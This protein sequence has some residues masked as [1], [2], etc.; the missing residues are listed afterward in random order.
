[1]EEETASRTQALTEQVRLLKAQLPLLLSRLSQIPDVRNPKKLKHKLTHLLLY[2]LLMFVYQYGSRREVNREM[3]RAMFQQ[4]LRELFPELAQLPHADT[5]YRLLEKIDVEAIQEAHIEFIRKLMKGKKFR[6]YLINN[7]YPVAID[8]TQ[9]LATELLWGEELLQ[10]K[11]KKSKEEDAQDGVTYQYYVYVL[12]ANLAF[13][14]GMVI[15]LLSEFLE[16]EQGDK[17]NNKQDCE[18]LAFK[19]LAKRLKDYFPKLQ[20]MLLLDGLY[21]NGPIMSC[22]LENKWQFMIV[23]PDKSLPSVWEQYHSMMWQQPHHGY[24]QHWGIRHQQFRWVN[25]IEYY[26][27]PNECNSLTLHVVVCEEQWQEVGEHG[28]IKTQTSRHVWISSR[29]L[30]KDNIHA[31][32]NLGARH[33]WGIEASFLVEKHQGYSYQ[34]CFAKNFNAMKGYHYLMR[35]AHTFN[36]L[37]RFSQAL[38]H[39][40][41]EL[42]VRGFLAF[43]RDTLKGPWLEPAVIQ[44][45]LARPFQLRLE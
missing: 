13:Q 24:S 34:H 26:Y 28:N 15:P 11:K 40:F 38:K 1:M 31:R 32:C 43:V 37:A 7:C 29:P 23:L 33:R 20:I 9:K 25:Q 19:R 8:G 39:S 22:C 6:R 4:N 45:Q 35:M 42:G 10:R 16:Y 12:E 21:P 18:N 41:Q 30:N 5:L 2:G 17:D 36:T 27:G 3:T 14:N 44:I